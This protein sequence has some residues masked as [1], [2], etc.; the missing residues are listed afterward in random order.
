MIL[1]TIVKL[2]VCTVKAA[3]CGHLGQAKPDIN[4]MLTIT[5]DFYSVIF[6]K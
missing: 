5:G 1:L 2:I 3:L 4:R 6:G